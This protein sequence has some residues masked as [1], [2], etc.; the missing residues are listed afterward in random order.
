MIKFVLPFRLDGLN[1][2]IKKC[3]SHHRV[4]AAYKKK[5]EKLIERSLATQTREEL[6]GFPVL[7][8]FIWREPN[9]RRDIDNVA[10]DKKFI[11]D[12]M[13]RRGILPNDSRRFVSGFIDE[14]PDPI[15]GDKTGSIEIYIYEESE[16]YAS[17]LGL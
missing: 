11:L 14:F 4:G 8:K 5:V 10:A 7:V 2:Y 3:R 1:T 13:V 12:A 15:E 17:L 6:K 9:R 16:D